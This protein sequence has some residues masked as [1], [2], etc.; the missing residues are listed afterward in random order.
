[1]SDVTTG[2][3]RRSILVA[4]EDVAGAASVWL[5]RRHRAV[6]VA[7]MLL[8]AVS[9]IS[10]SASKPFWHD[11]IYT[12]L[13]A[14][15]DLAAFRG[16]LLAGVD[17]SPPLNTLLT[18]GAVAIGGDGLL[19]TRLPALA[20]FWAAVAVVFVFVRRRSNAAMAAA[21]ALLLCFTAGYRFS[22]EARGYGVMMGLGALSLH[23]WSEAAAGRRRRRHVPLLGAALAAGYWANYHAVFAAAPILTGELTR[24]VRE[25]RIDAAI[26]AAIGASLLALLPLVPLIR[27][28]ASHVATFWHKPAFADLLPTYTF[29]FN[30]L[31]DPPVRWA[32]LAALTLGVLARAVRVSRVRGNGVPPWE[33]V[34]LALYVALPAVQ[35]L[36]AVATGGVFV[37]RYGLLAVPGACIAGA[38]VVHRL[39]SPSRAAP[40]VMAAVLAGTVAA[41]IPLRPSFQ[42]PARQRQALMEL[43]SDGRA[44]AVTGGLMYLQ[45]WYYTPPA[46][47]ERLHYLADRDLA[48]RYTGSTTID[49]GLAGLATWTGVNAVE[50]QRFTAANPEFHVYGAGSGWLLPW[51]RDHEASIEPLGTEMGAPIALVRLRR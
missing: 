47:R 29:L 1:M 13:L 38:L 41:T 33:P 22:Y 30:S 32:T 26:W 19:A 4:L 45:L 6:L 16:A 23:A 8:V 43:L 40:I 5:D 46:M 2:A 12:I 15:L 37:A 35:L 34:A 21:A 49:D 9:T 17:L 18:R 28:A 44:V 25:R 51:L 50:L 11:E 36:A 3:V 42:N 10:S 24:S 20:G 39:T 14:R 48:L 31:L 27:I 7:L